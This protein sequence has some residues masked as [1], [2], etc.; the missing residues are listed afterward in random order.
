MA[1]FEIILEWLS[2]DR[3]SIMTWDNSSSTPNVI[4]KANL[5]NQ[6]IYTDNKGQANWGTLYFAGPN[7]R[8]NFV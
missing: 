3:S 5:Q 7:V 2:G 1:H 8:L 6:Q 4:L